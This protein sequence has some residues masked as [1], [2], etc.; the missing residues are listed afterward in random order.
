MSYIAIDPG[1]TRSG[2]VRTLNGEIIEAGTFENDFVVGMIRDRDTVIIEWLQCYGAAIG[3]SV[4][5][6]AAMCGRVKQRCIH[7]QATYHEMT[8]PEVLRQLVGK[9]RGITKSVAKRATM[10]LYAA[11]GGGKTPEVGVMK[12]HGPLWKMKGSEHAWDAL[13][14]LEAW[15]MSRLESRQ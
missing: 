11:T 2:I 6:T 1:T 14:L 3:Q 8:R 4:L 15:K 7:K 12:D 10:D 13:S 5:R 9:T